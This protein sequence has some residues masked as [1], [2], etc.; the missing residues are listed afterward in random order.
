MTKPQPHTQKHKG[1]N[2]LNTKDL[3]VDGPSEQVQ[4][5]TVTFFQVNVNCVRCVC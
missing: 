1:E 5:L 4:V 3:T 2:V